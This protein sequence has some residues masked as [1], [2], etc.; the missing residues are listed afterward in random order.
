VLPLCPTCLEFGQASPR[1]SHG[2][3]L[4]SGWGREDPL[5]DSLDRPTRWN[6]QRVRALNPLAPDDA[7]LIASVVRG[8]FLVN[9]LRN[10]DLC[11]LLYPRPTPHAKEK[12]RRSAAVTRKLRLLRA[13][14]LIHKVPHTHRYVVSP[15]GQQTIT[16]LLA[17]RQASTKTLTEL[18]A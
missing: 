1:L 6:K 13:H 5:V 2:W 14:G 9:G 4:R 10:R 15:K 11:A 17:A 12:R 3:G 8:E 16:A 18:V 7:L